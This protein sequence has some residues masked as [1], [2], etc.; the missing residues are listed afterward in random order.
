MSASEPW[1][2]IALFT[3]GWRHGLEERTFCLSVFSRC[4]EK[5]N[6]TPIIWA[7]D[8]VRKTGYSSM[9]LQPEPKLPNEAEEDFLCC[10]PCTQLS[11]CTQKTPAHT[12]SWGV[13]AAWWALAFTQEQ[14]RHSGLN[15]HWLSKHKVILVAFRTSPPE[16]GEIACLQ[17]ISEQRWSLEWC[18]GA[19]KAVQCFS[20]VLVVGGKKNS[21]AH[22]ECL[23]K[24]GI[25]TI[26]QQNSIWQKVQP[27]VKYNRLLFYQ[28]IKSF[29]EKK[30]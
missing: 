18:L 30:F 22:Q 14:P 9:K 7:V 6:V 29:V 16:G 19:Q 20:V 28:E 15:Q 1:N 5:W 27:N 21:S 24:K 12:G 26:S 25:L 23:N 4:R 13:A 17:L 10:W 2:I 3:Q 11:H 8:S